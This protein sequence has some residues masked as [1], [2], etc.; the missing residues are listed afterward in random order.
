MH[1]SSSCGNHGVRSDDGVVER[2]WCGA[3]DS[4]RGVA[5]RSATAAAST[6][7]ELSVNAEAAAAGTTDEGDVPTVADSTAT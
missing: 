4:Q 1:R 5:T 6:W 3:V 2:V 7:F